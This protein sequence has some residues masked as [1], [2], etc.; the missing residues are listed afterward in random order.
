M[1]PKWMSAR[2]PG[3]RRSISSIVSVPR[4]EVEL[5][6]RA[7]RHDESARRRC[8]RR[9]HRPRRASRRRRDTRRG[10]RRALASGSTRDRGFGRRRRGRSRRHRRE[11]APERV[12]RDRRRACRALASSL[13]GSTRCGAPISET[14]TW[15][16]GFWRTSTPAAPAWSRWMCESRRWR[17]SVRSSPRSASPAFRC[18][19]DVVGPQSKSAGPS[20]VSSR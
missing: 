14:W 6:R 12:E 15:S 9:P 3:A 4:L 1:T 20:S 8:G 13:E 11:L 2:R 19:I 10:A 16:H 17:T 5:G 18:G 7:G